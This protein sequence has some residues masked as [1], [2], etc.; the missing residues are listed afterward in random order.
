M[1]PEQ[2]KIERHT[3]KVLWRIYYIAILS[4]VA[5]LFSSAYFRWS[6][7]PAPHGAMLE[8]ARAVELYRAENTSLTAH[9]EEGR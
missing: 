9:R 6:P 5:L 7:F 8:A 4:I 1:T 2:I 3:I